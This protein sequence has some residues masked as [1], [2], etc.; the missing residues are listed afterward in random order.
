MRWIRAIHHPREFTSRR[1][2]QLMDAWLTFSGSLPTPA[3]HRHPLQYHSM[4]ASSM[5]ECI[6]G[7]RGAPMPH[8]Q[9]HFWGGKRQ[10]PP[11]HTKNNYLPRGFRPLSVITKKYYDWYTN[12]PTPPARNPNYWGSWCLTLMSGQPMYPN[13]GAKLKGGQSPLSMPLHCH[14]R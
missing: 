14:C 9:P 3:C 13:V 2:H 4:M 10:S 1:S 7:L 5:C 11:T 8:A 12:Y 6:I